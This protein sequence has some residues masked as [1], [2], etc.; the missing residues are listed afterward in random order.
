MIHVHDLVKTFG[1]VKAVDHI[2]FDVSEASAITVTIFKRN[3]R[4]ATIPLPASSGHINRKL[5]TRK[6]KRGS[7]KLRIV[8]IDAAGNRSRP[9]TVSFK[10]R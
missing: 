7:Y 4:V 6:L 9:V 2:S 5:S 3:R 1:E 8:A 10:V